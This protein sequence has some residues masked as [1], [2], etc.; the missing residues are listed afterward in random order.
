MFTYC[1]TNLACG[2]VL[3]LT[4]FRFDKEDPEWSGTMYNLC[5][6]L[7]PSAAHQSGYN[8]IR[9]QTVHSFTVG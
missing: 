1:C 9:G 7:A 4:K 3:G 2:Q 6:H 8:L 5:F